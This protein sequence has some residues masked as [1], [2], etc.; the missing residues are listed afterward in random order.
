LE[1]ETKSNLKNLSKIS[2]NK[3]KKIKNHL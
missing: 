1:I 3:L 2:K